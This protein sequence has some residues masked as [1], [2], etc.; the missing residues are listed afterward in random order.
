MWYFQ[1]KDSDGSNRWAEFIL[2]MDFKEIERFGRLSEKFLRPLAKQ[3]VVII[4]RQ[5]GAGWVKERL[6]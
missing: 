6:K 1:I 5:T 2:D 3:H 4:W